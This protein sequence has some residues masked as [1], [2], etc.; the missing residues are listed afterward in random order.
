[1]AE[2]FAVVLSDVCWIN[3]ELGWNF[4]ASAAASGKNNNSQFEFTQNSNVNSNPKTGQVQD[5]N[6]WI[7]QHCD[8]K[9]CLKSTWRHMSWWQ[10]NMVL[11]PQE[12][13]T[14]ITA[15]MS[16]FKSTSGPAPEHQWCV[17]HGWYILITQQICEWTTSN[18][19]WEQLKAHWLWQ[20]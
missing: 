15:V 11:A 12:T 8:M 3:H 13:K 20:T 7:F 2:C 9:F 14:K 5:L 16:S 4:T 17:W 19:S 18:P 1:M 10:I 6:Y